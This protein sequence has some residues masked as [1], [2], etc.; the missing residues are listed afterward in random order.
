[1]YFCILQNRILKSFFF[2]FFSVTVLDMA[3]HIP[4]YRAALQLLR[5]LAASSQLI[6]LLLPQKSKLHLQSISCLLKN[7]KTCVDTYA[8]KLK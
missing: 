4:L 2:F 1:M 7:M 6:D 3:R 8:S 5:A